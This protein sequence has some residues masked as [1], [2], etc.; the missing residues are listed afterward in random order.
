MGTAKGVLVF[1]DIA[2]YHYA[3]G[4]PPNMKGKID[5]TK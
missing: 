5:V 3:C 1:N 2:S 4:L